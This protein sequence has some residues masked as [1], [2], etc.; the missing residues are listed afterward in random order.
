MLGGVDRP[1]EV[2][3]HG[4]ELGH[5][6]LRRPLDLGLGVARHAL[7]VVVEVGRDAAQ[8]VQVLVRPAPRLVELRLERA[9]RVVADGLV[10]LGAGALLRG[11]AVTPGHRSRRPPRRRRSPRRRTRRF[12]VRGAVAAARALLSLLGLLVDDLAQLERGLAQR[13]E[14]R[15]DLAGVIALER[16]PHRLELRADVGLRLLVEPVLVLLEGLLRRVRDLLGRVAGLGQLLHAAVVLG[17]RLGVAH[18]LVD[19]AVGEARS[20]LDL[21]LLL[22]TRAQ[23]LGRHVHDPVGVDVERDL[24]LGHASRRR[25]DADELELAQRLVVDGHLAL[26]LEHVDLDGRLSV[27]RGGE[28]LRLAG[29]DGRVAVDQLGEH[30][31]LGLDPERQRG[32]VE[33]QDVLD[34]ALQHPGLDGG[35]DG[36]DLVRV[37]A[38]VRVLADQVLDLLLHGRH[39]GHAA[40]QDDLVDVG[41]LQAGVRQRLLGRAD[42]ALDQ[43]AGELGQLR[44]AERRVEVLRPL[45]VGRD[46]RQVDVR[47]LRRRELDLGLLRGLVQPLERHRILAQVDALVAL[48]LGREPV[49][50]G[51][52]EVVAAQVVVTGRRLDL[53]HALTQLQHRHVERA[54]AEVEDEDRL[55]ALLVEPVGERCRRRLVD[56]PQHLEAG[57]LAGVL[58]GVALGVVEVGRD[59]DHGLAHGLAQVGLGV[60]LQL[61]QDHG[62]DLRRRN[63][64]VAGLDAGVAVRARR[65][66]VGDDLLL[67]GDLRGLAAHEPLDRE[68]RVL[69]VRHRLPL[70]RRADQTLPILGEGDDRRGRATA[71]GVGDDG[72]LSALHHRHARVC[73]AQV[74]ANHS[75]HT[76]ATPLVD[77]TK[78]IYVEL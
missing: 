56:D 35:A 71:L 20:A 37:D 4:Q 67:L 53:E 18:H 25:R 48:E 61:L 13:L 77:S 64:L 40:D 29:R 24:D 59:G 22:V 1:L 47:R 34:L 2:V 38:A 49:D 78:Q 70:G 14:P 55:V 75:C 76:L 5:D 73:R 27:L 23:V 36:D 68:D 10:G 6:R 31:T 8:V 7:A 62:R 54:A 28:D 57:D 50:D 11:S 41:R 39:A 16:L 52:V 66:L 3:E 43:L 58:G 74:D 51:L 44:P 33:Q 65:D 26:T 12:T 32:H 21:D 63:D 46:E 69:G 60:G 15:P 9:G 72:G 30:A 19:L 45:G 42:R 17:V